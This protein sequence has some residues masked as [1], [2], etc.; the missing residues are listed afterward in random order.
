MTGTPAADAPSSR[1]SPGV[2]IDVAFLI[3][4]RIT[5]LDAIGPY[6]VLSRLPG[7]T[8]RF[9]A[10][11]PG[12]ISTDTGFLSLGGDYGLDDV[13]EPDVLVVPGG[14]GIR[15]LLD[16]ERVLDW[17]RAVHETSRWTASVC[18]GALLLGAAGVLDGM[19]ATT[20]WAAMERLADYGAEATHSRIVENG[21]VITAAGVSAGIDLG[22]RLAQLLA[23]QEMA[24]A[25]QLV[26]EYDPL[27]QFDAGSPAAAGPETVAL[28]RDLLG[29]PFAT[30]PRRGRQPSHRDPESGDRRH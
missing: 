21:K 29:S 22:L 5:A 7:A 9:V 16:D 24:R 26:I 8:V 11:V 10:P 3:F 13:V 28:A 12:P 23:G 19:P 20:H 27:D 17:I 14:P 18:T 2:G 6:E 4:D 25:I 1:P 15:A 30:P